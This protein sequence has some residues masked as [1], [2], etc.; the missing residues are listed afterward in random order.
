MSVQRQLRGVP[1]PALAS[2]WPG[3]SV[4]CWVNEPAEEVKALCAELPEGADVL[5]QPVS[6]ISNLLV[7]QPAGHGGVTRSSPISRT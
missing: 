7:A 5:Y 4:E 3:V 2:G 6:R 1:P